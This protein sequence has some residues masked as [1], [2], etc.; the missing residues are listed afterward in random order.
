MGWSPTR[1]DCEG[2]NQTEIPL[3]QDIVS[4]ATDE[5]L[6]G[7]AGASRAI[8]NASCENDT[9]VYEEQ[10][11]CFKLF[12]DGA[13]EDYKA[14]LKQLYF[15]V[16]V[17]LFLDMIYAGQKVAAKIFYEKHSQDFAVEPHQ[18]HLIG[19]LSGIVD[20]MDILMNPAVESFREGKAVVKFDNQVLDYL[21]R[22]LQCCNSTVLIKCLDQHIALEVTDSSNTASPEEGKMHPHLIKKQES[23]EKKSAHTSS[24]DHVI[25]KVQTGPPSMPSICHYTVL[26]TN[27]RLACTSLSHDAQLLCGGFENSSLQVWSLTSKKLKRQQRAADVSKIHVAGEFIEEKLEAESV[28]SDSK[29]LRGHSGPVYDCT[30]LKNSNL[31]LSCSEDSTVRSWDLN[32][33]TNTSSYK[34]HNYPVWCIDS[35][36]MGIYFATG[37]KDRSAR[38]WSLERLYPLRIYAG[39]FLD[40]DCIRFHSNNNYLAT[41]SSDKTVRVWSIQDGKCVRILTGHKGSINALEFSPD[42]KV[43][44]S[45]GEDRRIR[46]WDLATGQL[47]KELR[48]HSNTVYGLSF[49]PNGAMLASGGSDNI[50]KLWDVRNTFRQNQSESSSSLELL[51]SFQSRSCSIQY[52]QFFQCNLLYAAG[53]GS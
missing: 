19:L 7:I 51:G 32:T 42:G 13:I 26:N 6:L 22:F 2:S 47:L 3:A 38:L 53:A 29:T 36:P 34:G 37:S 21:L 27:Q 52:L 28:G 39:H 24:L 41:G 46:L 43:L 10:Y 31:L 40:V 23:L 25:H 1:E 44:A 9:T 5:L 17:H 30:F 4:M 49:S 18:Q 20:R 11:K 15:P 45:A 8:S 16:F 50:L 14:S 33:Y 48:G 12:I 35:G